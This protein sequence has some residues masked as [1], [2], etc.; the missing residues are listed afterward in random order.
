MSENNRIIFYNC[1]GETVMKQILYPANFLLKSESK[2]CINIVAKY[3]R[4]L[5]AL[6]SLGGNY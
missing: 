6:E 3:G 1:W 4:S 2:V 5:K